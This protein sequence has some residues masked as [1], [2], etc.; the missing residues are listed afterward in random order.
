MGCFYPP[1]GVYSPGGV[2]NPPLTRQTRGIL[3]GSPI[4]IPRTLGGPRGNGEKLPHFRQK[5]G[6]FAVKN[7]H[8]LV[9]LTPPRGYPPNG[10][11]MASV[12]P[13]HRGGSDPPRGGSDPLYRGSIQLNSPILYGISVYFS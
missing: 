2:K 1:G 6:V 8:F 3:V 7:D 10:G 4:L 12:D 5:G 13:P 9:V 11:Y